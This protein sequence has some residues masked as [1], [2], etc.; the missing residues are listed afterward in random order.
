MNEQSYPES[1]EDDID[2]RDEQ[3]RPDDRER[4][5]ETTEDQMRGTVTAIIKEFVKLAEAYGMTGGDLT[6][7]ERGI[8]AGVQMMSHLYLAEPWLP[9][10]KIMDALKSGGWV[11][12]LDPTNVEW[13]VR[14]TGGSTHVYE[15]DAED[16]AREWVAESAVDR[17]L[18]RE[19]VS[20]TAAGPWI[21]TQ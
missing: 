10:S 14:A 7:R 2:S 8:Q 4:P 13:G 17:A 15:T 3:E 1:I 18:S 16:D 11:A 19:V 12:P 6:E 21:A 9:A 5:T 20:R